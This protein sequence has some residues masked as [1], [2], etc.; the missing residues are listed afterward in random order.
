MNGELSDEASK[1]IEPCLDVLSV[2]PILT[3]VSPTLNKVLEFKLGSISIL[4]I[5]IEP[6]DYEFFKLPSTSI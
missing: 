1:N 2:L 3:T 5:Y 4:N 6:S